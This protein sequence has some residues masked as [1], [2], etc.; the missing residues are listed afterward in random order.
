MYQNLTNLEKNF[1]I[2]YHMLQSPCIKYSGI[3]HLLRFDEKS[4]QID[5]NGKIRLIV[6][7]EKLNR[8]IDIPTHESN[9]FILLNILYVRNHRSILLRKQINEEQFL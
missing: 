4:E 9:Q 5:L 7:S 3:Q 2:R 1:S 8:F 6:S